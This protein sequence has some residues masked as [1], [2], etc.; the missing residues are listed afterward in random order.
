M[1]QESTN[2]YKPDATR[3]SVLTGGAVATASAMLS[4]DRKSVV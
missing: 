2:I 3:R 1:K 4:I